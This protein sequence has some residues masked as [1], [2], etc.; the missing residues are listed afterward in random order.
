[1]KTADTVCIGDRLLLKGRPVTVTNVDRRD[2]HIRLF[3]IAEWPGRF[4]AGKAE[5]MNEEGTI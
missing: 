3:E 5:Q 1:M 2:Q 4:W